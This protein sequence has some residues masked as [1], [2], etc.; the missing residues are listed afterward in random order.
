MSLTIRIAVIKCM[1]KRALTQFL[2]IEKQRILSQKLIKYSG[3][4]IKYFCR[5]ER[6]KGVN[7]RKRGVNGAWK[8]PVGAT[9]AVISFA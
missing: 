6:N 8:K 2:R 3:F 1:K 9:G 5:K 4:I 7:G